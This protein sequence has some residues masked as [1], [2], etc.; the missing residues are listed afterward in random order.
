MKEYDNLIN[1]TNQAAQVSYQGQDDTQTN[2][3]LE[4]G[5]EI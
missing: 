3:F 1:C 5:D 4:I 2:K